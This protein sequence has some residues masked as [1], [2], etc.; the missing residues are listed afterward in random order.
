MSETSLTRIVT[1]LF[2]PNAS[3]W[4]KT[5]LL[6]FRRF[7]TRVLSFHLPRHACPLDAD[8]TLIGIL[9]NLLLTWKRKWRRVAHRE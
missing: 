3:V 6:C 2:I 9:E 1:Q 8:V 5:S 4:F 7:G